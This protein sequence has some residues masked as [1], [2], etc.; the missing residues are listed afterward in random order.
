[1]PE[2]YVAKVDELSDRERRIVVEDALEIGVFRL[3]DEFFAWESNRVNEVLE[4]A[5]RAHG[6]EFVEADVHIICPW[7][8]YEF[9]IRTG[10][11]PGNPDAR[12]RGFPVTIRD[13]AVY[14]T[15]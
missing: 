1:V 9:N 7:H 6:Y 5:K 15:I 4:E 14:V 8:G 11:H 10:V 13:G 3:G 2:L 12:L